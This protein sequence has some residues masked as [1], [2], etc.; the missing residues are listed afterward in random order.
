MIGYAPSDPK[1]S[2]YTGLADDRGR[3]LALYRHAALDA[4][5]DGMALTRVPR[6]MPAGDVADERAVLHEG[7]IDRAGKLALPPQ[8]TQAGDF[9]QGR[10][11]VV[12]G[13]RLALIDKSGKVLLQ[14]AW[15]CGTRQPVL[16]DGANKVVWPQGASQAGKCKG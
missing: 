7:Y 13:K 2:G 12:A 10:A 4:M 15:M 1:L 6:A 5:H 14:G 8:Y 16:L 11:T 9:A 3:T